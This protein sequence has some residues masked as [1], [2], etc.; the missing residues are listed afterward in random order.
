MPP[1]RSTAQRRALNLSRSLANI[2][3]PKFI[4]S[5][6]SRPQPT[7]QLNP[8]VFHPPP[9]VP[10]YPQPVI[11]RLREREISRPRNLRRSQYPTYRIAHPHFIHLLP[12]E[13]LG[14]IFALG[15]EEDSQLPMSVSHVC[16]QWREIAL[17]TPAIW[18]R[19]S[20]SPHER[21]WRER[22]HRTRAH[23]LDVELLPWRTVRG[24]FKRSQDLNAYTVQWYMY[25]VLPF[26]YRW[27][28]LEIFFTDS[29]PY[30]WRAALA[31]C[32]TPAPMLEE[33]S[34]VYRFNDNTQE[35]LLF[36]EHA[37]R[38][39]RLTVDGIRLT[40]SPRLYGN[41]TFLD[42]THHGFT[43]GHQAVHD[44]ISSL[45]ICTRLVELRILFPRGQVS[46]LSSR[47][48]YVTK[49]IRLR[50]LQ[51]LQ[52][53]VDGSDIPFEL[54]HLVTLLN[55]PRLTSLRLVDISQSYHSFPS[56]KSF[57]YVFPL[58]QSLQ[59]I[60]VNYGWYDHR[61]IQPMT[62]S[63]PYLSKIVIKRSRAPE[64]VLQYHPRVK[65]SS[66]V[67]RTHGRSQRHYHMNQLNV[68]YP[69]AGIMA[70]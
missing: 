20:L 35:F 53:S 63:L 68:P 62:Q 36:G 9:E 18:R 6:F 23:P 26:I 27:R 41:L 24:G 58:P 16:K 57:F 67:I 10:Q 55:A 25:L 34:L 42:Y 8:F 48:E 30:L 45:S 70:R 7:Q 46:R 43:S 54:A 14:L 39:R 4:W 44:V 29:S 61:M 17:H 5:F 38:L 52:L 32:G 2:F 11:P 69:S 47:R 1:S 50:A 22:I 21:L 65:Q 12:Y 60:Q 59:V 66:S 56:L 51:T 3:V 19:I 49:R 28:S 13:I 37:P 40:W 31:G 33:L 15:A 64:Q